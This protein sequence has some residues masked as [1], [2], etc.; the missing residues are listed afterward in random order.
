[1]Y[2]LNKQIDKNF[3]ELYSFL[4]ILILFNFATYFFHF[5][6]SKEF[7][8]A[9][10]DSTIVSELDNFIEY[11]SFNNS[12]FVYSPF[13]LI[14]MLIPYFILG[15]NYFAFLITTKFFLPSLS[16]IFSYIIAR[17]VLK[18][19]FLRLCFLL[20][21]IT[22]GVTVSSSSIRHVFPELSLIL[23]ILILNNSKNYLKFFYIGSLF[24]V[25][26][27]ISYEYG[28]VSFFAFFIAQVFF[29]KKLFHEYNF[30]NILLL[31][32]GIF[33][34]INIFYFFL[35]YSKSTE[36]Y[37]SFLFDLYNNFELIS[38]A[39][40]LLLPDIT[41]LNFL[42]P[43]NLVD[44]IFSKDFKF[45]LPYLIYFIVLLLVIFRNI[46][47]KKRLF[48]VSLTIY[49]LLIQ[50]RTINGPAYG[51]LLYSYLPVLIFIFLF[52]EFLFDQINI[53]PFRT[54]KIKYFTNYKIYI[55]SF[56]FLFL[57]SSI[58]FKP[59]STTRG[60]LKQIIEY[61]ISEYSIPTIAKDDKYEK[62]S[63]TYNK[64]LGV[65]VRSKVSEK[66]N[67]VIDYVNTLGVD[68]L[69][70][71]PWGLYNNMLNY[72][73]LIRY[74]ESTLYVGV[75]NNDHTKIMVTQLEKKMPEYILLNLYY[76]FGTV[77]ISKF[78]EGIIPQVYSSDYINFAGDLN[79]LKL[80]I[81][82]NYKI[83]KIFDYAVVL[84]KR[85]KKLKYQRKYQYIDF[86]NDDLTVSSNL[87]IED[88][89]DI[90][91]DF[92]KEKTAYISYNDKSLDHQYIEFTMKGINPF[93]KKILS[94]NY[95]E[96]VLFTDN[97]KKISRK[98]FVSTKKRKVIIPV[99]VYEEGNDSI[100]SINFEI[101][102]QFPYFLFKKILL[103][104]FKYVV[105]QKQNIN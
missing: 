23:S 101:T 39:F 49:G 44:F 76:N 61:Y 96:I 24:S 94:K 58:N 65:R 95:V 63:F 54:N 9:V 81:I 38:G 62:I 29:F 47:H 57:I 1:M 7:F 37:I 21:A 67:R 66:F 64:Y 102:N 45:Y 74:S 3:F 43:L 60:G 35:D 5:P 15:K 100:K 83:D 59:D 91:I 56:I 18:N 73:N 79:P 11:K 85:F 88:N 77:A 53:I 17:I 30:I 42:N 105:F 97:N 50:I 78:R 89:K 46:G 72:K 90:I 69:Y 4:F 31:L 16:I 6:V 48:F 28:A 70:V 84:K 14:L 55:I 93:Y 82:E 99:K 104:N 25:S 32:F 103:Q 41:K 75:L 13:N 27:L 34:Y 71:Y 86:I 92:S 2:G 10:D 68:E 12:S 8:A 20:S 52:L 19:H 98:V 33:F 26:F 87:L 80:F 22:I 51:Y 40:Y 36:Y